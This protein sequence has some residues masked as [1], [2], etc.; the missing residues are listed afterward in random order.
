MDPDSFDCL[1]LQSFLK[2]WKVHAEDRCNVTFW[3]CGDICISDKPPEDRP[4]CH[5]GSGSDIIHTFEQRW[6]C[7]K[8][9]CDCLG[10]WVHSKRDWDLG[11]RMLEAVQMAKSWVSASRVKENATPIPNWKDKTKSISQCVLPGQKNNGI[12]NCVNRAFKKSYQR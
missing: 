8:E 12:F 9:P 10:S 11:L 4:I 1:D 3:R 5:C 6:C 7:S 2:N